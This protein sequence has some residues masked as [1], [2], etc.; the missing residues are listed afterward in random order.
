MR[1][2]WPLLLLSLSIALAGRPV[3]AD[4]PRRATLKAPTTNSA[5]PNRVATLEI[6]VDGSGMTEPE[7]VARLMET[8]VGG[9]LDPAVLELDLARLRAT[10][11]LFDTRVEVEPRPDGEHVTL[12]ASDKWSLVPFLSFKRGG[13]R[14]TAKLG[15]WDNDLLGR[16]ITLSAEI[17][18]NA[19]VPF[20]ARKSSD[21]IGHLV[22][23]N[24]PRVAGLP[25]TPY[26]G[27]S[28]QY[29]DFARWNGQ[30]AVVQVYD[31]ARQVVEGSLRWDLRGDLALISGVAWTRDRHT[32]SSR[33]PT[34]GALPIDVDLVAGTLA[35]QWGLIDENLTRFRGHQLTLQLEAAPGGTYGSTYGYATATLDVKQF[36]IPRERHTLAVR[37]V[38]AATSGASDST[39]LRAGGQGEIRG[40]EDSYFVGAQ[41]ARTN[42]EYR[43]E[44]GALDVPFRTRWQ[45]VSHVDAGLVRKREG[46]VAGLDYTGPVLGVGSGV[47]ITIVPIAKSVG[48][49]DAAFGL[50]PRP[51]FD[52]VLGTQQF[53]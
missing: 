40:F 53:F 10:S 5:L 25:L 39:L 50:W 44:V 11:V 18:S 49:I 6:E 52:I 7:S 51:A 20:L 14:T 42:V 1:R 30:G 19:D 31:R 24:V 32:Q 28:R 16:L 22:F 29:V 38:L 12:K 17:T 45:V 46:A 41:L 15:A 23:L 21:R 34:P 8:K 27:W 13:A 9:E 35:L 37:A 33:S 36:W 2:S 43:V 48:R 26:V 4:E 47:R 3:R